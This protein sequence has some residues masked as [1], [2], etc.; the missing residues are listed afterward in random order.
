[1][2][3]S[4]LNEDVSPCHAT[5]LK[6]SS[7]MMGFFDFGEV[8]GYLPDSVEVGQVVTQADYKFTR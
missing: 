5:A 3:I 1:M 6:T 2:S 8:G 4:V 7:A